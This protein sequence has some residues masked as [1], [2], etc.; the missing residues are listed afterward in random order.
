MFNSINNIDICVLCSGGRGAGD[1]GM[2]VSDGSG[3]SRGRAWLYSTTDDFH[4]IVN[5]SSDQPHCRIG[6]ITLNSAQLNQNQT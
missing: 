1:D 4:I 5:T 2:M 6:I 3:H